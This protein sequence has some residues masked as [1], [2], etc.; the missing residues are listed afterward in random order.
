M[1]ALLIAATA[2]LDRLDLVKD[3]CN[4][5]KMS[6][7][8]M[9]IM[10][11]SGEMV[12]LIR[13]AYLWADS[14]K[15]PVAAKTLGP[16]VPKPTHWKA[17]LALHLRIEKLEG[18]GKKVLFWTVEPEHIVDAERLALKSRKKHRAWVAS[19]KAASGACAHHWEN[20][21]RQIPAAQELARRLGLKFPTS[22]KLDTSNELLK[23]W[24]YPIRRLVISGADTPENFKLLFGPCKY[25]RIS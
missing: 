11:T 13:T 1:M 16:S 8:T 14:T 17:I 22:K 5:S 24:L 21:A 9:Y 20:K 23:M 18:M 25:Y 3:I 15:A 19:N 6:F 7:A 12:N 4:G 2:A 10:T